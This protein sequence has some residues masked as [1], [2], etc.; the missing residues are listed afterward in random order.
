MI[1]EECDKILDEKLFETDQKEVD[2]IKKAYT[3]GFKMERAYRGCGQCTLLAL[4]ETTGNYDD[5]LFQD[6]S[7]M[8][9]GMGLCGDG[10]CGGYI[11]G[12]LFMGKYAGRRRE[13]MMIDGDK[14]AQYRSY[15]MAQELH[16][17]ILETYGD[18]VCKSIHQLIFGRDYCLRT[19]PVRDAFEEAGAHTVKCTGVIAMISTFVIRILLK[20][21]YIKA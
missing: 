21:G 7:A 19:K 9:G 14:E 6:S 20:Y 8:S 1:C 16:D 17:M 15:D 12:I 2:L 18:V 11:C 10:A 13:Q 4:Y 3:A 5:A